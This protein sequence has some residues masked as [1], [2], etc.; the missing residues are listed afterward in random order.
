MA[1]QS[2]VEL[3]KWGFTFGKPDMERIGLFAEM[4][5]MNGKGYVSPF[6]TAK[7]KNMKSLICPGH[8]ILAGTQDGLFESQFKRIFEKEVIVR[9]KK[10]PK[11]KNI[12]ERPFISCCGSKLHATPGDYFGCFSGNISAFSPKKR[13]EPKKPPEKLPFLTNPGKKGG[14]GYIDTTIGK[15]PTYMW[16]RYA[17]K[18]KYK[19]YGKNLAG[20]MRTMIYPQPFFGPDPYPDPPNVKK[21]RVYIKPAEKSYGK[22][23]GTGIY[24]PT[25]PAKWPGGMHAGGFEKFPSHMPERYKSVYEALKPK[26]EPKVFYPQSMQNKSFYYTSILNQNVDFRVSQDN[27]AVFQPKYLKYLINRDN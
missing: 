13:P 16:S 21:G 12:S 22:P 27:H 9:G 18:P 14:P 7:T 25:G 15:Y 10:A 6:A 17:Q 24:I 3:T 23:L 1:K 19:Q 26:R 20:P 2:P 8:K 5:Y 4:P 11:G